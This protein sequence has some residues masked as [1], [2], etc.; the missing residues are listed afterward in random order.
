MVL[1]EGGD[2]A[3]LAHPS[4]VAQE[5]PVA[6]A[7]GQTLVELHVGVDYA[8]QLGVAQQLCLHVLLQHDRLAGGVGELGRCQGRALHEDVGV[9]DERQTI[10]CVELTDGAG[11][12][13]G[14][15][16]G[17]GVLHDHD[18]VLVIVL[19]RRRCRGA[20]RFRSPRNSLRSGLRLRLGSSSSRVGSTAG[21][22]DRRVGDPGSDRVPRSGRMCHAVQIQ[23]TLSVVAGA[24]AGCR[25]C[26]ELR[27]HLNFQL[28]SAASGKS[29]PVGVGNLGAADLRENM[30]CWFR[31]GS[32]T[33]REALR[34]LW[35]DVK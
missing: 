6:L 17:V 18:I 33:A 5:E 8:F 35:S 27:I 19:L 11:G 22:R 1:N 2:L 12:V 20:G 21:R 26:K 7:V 32:C 24:Q 9:T 23:Q 16:V 13:G 29:I 4:A 3:A 10:I 28:W 30:K 25:G 31:V 14:E 34:E 15:G